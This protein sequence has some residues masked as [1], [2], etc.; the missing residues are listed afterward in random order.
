M[1]MTSG[2]TKG[3]AGDAALGLTPGSNGLDDGTQAILTQLLQQLASGGTP[4]MQQASSA[5]QSEVGNLEAQR[6]GFSKE[7]AFADAQGLIAQTMRQALEKLIPNI[8]SA[9]LG[10]GASQSSMRALLTQRAAENASQQASAE[11]IRAATNYGQVAGGISDVI[12][13]LLSIQDPS[14]EL[15]IRAAGAVRSPVSGTSAGGR[16]AAAQ[17][18]SQGSFG[19]GSQVAYAPQAPL[20]FGG[21]GGSFAQPNTFRQYETIEAPA[22]QNIVGSTADTLRELAGDTSFRGYTF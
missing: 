13:R 17:P 7:A 1:A 21:G 19:G 5:R 4:Q 8:N 10:A 3:T 15:L 20:N 14:A 6:A 9:S 12:S 18:A 16:T 22:T 2:A 11:G